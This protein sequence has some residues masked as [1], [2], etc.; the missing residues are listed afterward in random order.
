[1]LLGLKPIWCS[2]VSTML[3]VATIQTIRNTAAFWGLINLE[4]FEHR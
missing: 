3:M 1:M 4:S 2:N